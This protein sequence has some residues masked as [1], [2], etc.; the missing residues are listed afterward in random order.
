[1]CMCPVC[2]NRR[3][4]E[5]RREGA[6]AQR[7]FFALAIAAVA[8][9]HGLDDDDAFVHLMTHASDFPEMIQ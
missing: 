6:Q 1:M 2:M 7:D 8:E 4:Q 5:E 9:R 3:M